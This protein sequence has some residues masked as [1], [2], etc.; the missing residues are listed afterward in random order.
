MKKSQSTDMDENKIGSDN[1]IKHEQNATAAMTS[2]MPV[3]EE[4]KEV[5]H[6]EE[7]NLNVRA[8]IVHMMGDMI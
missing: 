1:D 6:G 8:A 7:E 3:V 4:V 2:E 5:K